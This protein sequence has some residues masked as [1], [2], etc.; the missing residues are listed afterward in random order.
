MNWTEETQKYEV[1]RRKKKK[2]KEKISNRKGK[3][4]KAKKIK[5]ISRIKGTRIQFEGDSRPCQCFRLCW[6]VNLISKVENILASLWEILG[7]IEKDSYRK[8]TIFRFH[9]VGRTSGQFQN[10][11]SPRSNPNYF[12][13]QSNWLRSL[14]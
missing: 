1:C 12:Y 2:V 14:T 4:R 6:H 5:A 3:K 8:L 11:L 10:H 9:E 7:R 13:L